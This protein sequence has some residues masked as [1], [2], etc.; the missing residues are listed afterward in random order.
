MLSAVRGNR[1]PAVRCLPGLNLVGENVSGTPTATGTSSFTVKVTDS[2]S[3]SLLM[4]LLLTINSRLLTITNSLLPAGTV[5]IAY[6]Q[7]LVAT[8]GSPPYTWSLVNGSFPD[9]L[10]LSPSGMISGTATAIGPSS[11]TVRVTDSI[12]ASTTATLSL[13]ID[14]PAL[15]ITTSSLPPGAVG[16]AYSK[17]LNATEWISA[18]HVGRKV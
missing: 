14:S 4:P 12:S 8:G 16:A 9:G 17:T 11:F 1:W 15:T 6:A 13:T 7:G 3:A 18:V 10:S 2:T 5:G